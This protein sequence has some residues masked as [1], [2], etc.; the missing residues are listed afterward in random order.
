MDADRRRMQGQGTGKGDLG[1]ILGAML[2]GNRHQKGEL[3]LNLMLEHRF[4]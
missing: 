4:D 1:H 3:D 2:A